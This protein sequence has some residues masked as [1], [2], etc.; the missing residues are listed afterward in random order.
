MLLDND[1]T[2][3]GARSTGQ[4][5]RDPYAQFPRC[6]TVESGGSSANQTTID[7]AGCG[8]FLSYLEVRTC[9]V[10]GEVLP[11]PQP[12]SR[13]KIEDNSPR[14]LSQPSCNHQEHAVDRSGLGL[15]DKHHLGQPGLVAA[16][17][18]PSTSVSRLSRLKAARPDSSAWN[19]FEAIYV[20][21]ICRWIGRTAEF[22]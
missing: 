19:R 15:L 2:S 1:E 10:Q 7:C 17:V 8:Y 12:F 22:F 11:T 3:D 16:S 6:G 20:P 18:A 14:A 21:L 5:T 4:V 9:A 13:S